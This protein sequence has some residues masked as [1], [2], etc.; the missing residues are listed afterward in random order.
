MHPFFVAQHLHRANPECWGKLV[1]CI[2]QVQY[3]SNARVRYLH[4]EQGRIMDEFNVST[5]DVYL[6]T[7]LAAHYHIQGDAL[8]HQAAF[9]EQMLNWFYESEPD[10]PGNEWCPKGNMF[11]CVD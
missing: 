8:H 5:M 6:G 7:Y 3:M 11:H 9:S 10:P 4:R 2:G 1:D